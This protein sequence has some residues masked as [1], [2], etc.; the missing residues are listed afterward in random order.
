MARSVIGPL[1]KYCY[2]YVVLH[3]VI[4]FP[5]ITRSTYQLTSPSLRLI[6]RENSR[7]AYNIAWLTVTLSTVLSTLPHLWHDWHK[8]GGLWNL[9]YRLKCDRQLA[10]DQTGPSSRCLNHTLLCNLAVINACTRLATTDGKFSD[11]HKSTRTLNVRLLRM[12][13]LTQMYLSS[14]SECVL[15]YHVICKKYGCLYLSVTLVNLNHLL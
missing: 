13:Q 1:T 5:H 12:F 14:V 6:K 10:I 3:L 4:M 9:Y 8:S 11:L 15:R 2:C 7:S